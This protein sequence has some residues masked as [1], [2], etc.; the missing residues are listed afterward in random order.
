MTVGNSTYAIVASWGDSGVQ[1]I[2]IT[3]PASPTPTASVTDGI[4]GFDEL[5]R[6]TDVDTVTVGNSTYAIVAS[7]YD[8]GVQIINITN[9]ASPTPTASVSDGIGGFDE[10]GGAWN[11]DTVTVGNSTYAIVASWDDDG[12]QIINITNPASP[13]PTASVTD[14]IGGFDELDGAWGVDTVTVGNSTY[15]IVTSEHDDGVQIIN[16]TNPASPTPTASVSDGIGGFDE[17]DGAHSVDTVTVGSSTYAIVTSWYDDGVQ[18][19]DITHLP[20]VFNGLSPVM[21]LE[22][23]ATDRHAIFSSLNQSNTLVFTYV[24]QENDTSDDLDYTS[25]NSISFGSATIVSTSDT[26]IHT[27]LTLPTPGAV[28]SLGY[29]KDIVINTTATQ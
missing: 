6:A 12:V 18:I 7:E 28:N 1:I 21:T 10:L 23:G 20:L 2:N 25:T 22:T 17:L 24:V 29:N 26:T 3:N 5:S 15:A 8:D 19:I 4:G 14:G 16:I 27:N 9:P 13:T 11:V